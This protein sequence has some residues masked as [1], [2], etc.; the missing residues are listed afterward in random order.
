MLVVSVLNDITQTHLLDSGKGPNQANIVQN[1]RLLAIDN[2][3]SIYI[4]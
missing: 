3:L 4:Q 2:H 1:S